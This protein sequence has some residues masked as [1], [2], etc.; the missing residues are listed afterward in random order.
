MFVSGLNTASFCFESLN[1]SLD[2]FKKTIILFIYVFFTFKILWN[3]KLK[4][5]TAKDK[6]YENY[7]LKWDVA[8]LPSLPSNK[9]KKRTPLDRP[10]IYTKKQERS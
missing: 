10:W 2:P 9:L 1:S 3:I 4:L 5:L 6:K 7:S 8:G